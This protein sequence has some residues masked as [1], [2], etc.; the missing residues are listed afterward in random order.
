MRIPDNVSW[1][2]MD[3]L[4]VIVD[5]ATGEYYSLN[6]SAS[7]IWSAMAD[8]KSRNEI[9]DALVGS[10]EVDA[11]QAESDV[12]SCIEK[13]LGYGILHMGK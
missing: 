4:V 11:Q 5:V 6:D 13:W 2:Q 3:D 9:V 1:K 12:S 8:G 7:S 10:Y